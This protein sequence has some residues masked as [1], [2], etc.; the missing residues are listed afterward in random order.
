M[1]L[2][3]LLIVLRWSTVSAIPTLLLSVLRMLFLR[4]GIA[5]TLDPEVGLPCISVLRLFTTHALT[6]FTS[7]HFLLLHHTF[8]FLA[9][10]DTASRALLRV[11]NAALRCL[12]LLEVLVLR[13][14][15]PD[16]R[17]HVD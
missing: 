8:I 15:R 12:P 2:L 17:A 4:T 10:I 11:H 6:I 13:C 16:K 7:L 9:T 1:L 3:L 5:C 14:L